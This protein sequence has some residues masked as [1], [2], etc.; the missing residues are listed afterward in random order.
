MI[1]G[2]EIIEIIKGIFDCKTEKK[3][4]DDFPRLELF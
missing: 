2:L 3:E 4:C 1:F